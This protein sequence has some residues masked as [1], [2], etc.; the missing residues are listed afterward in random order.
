MKRGYGSDH[1]VCELQ[2][3]CDS[4]Q[5][6]IVTLD[7]NKRGI[8]EPNGEWLVKTWSVSSHNIVLT[9]N[10]ATPDRVQHDAA[11]RGVE[12]WLEHRQGSCRT[13]IQSWITPRLPDEFRGDDLDYAVGM[14][15]VRTPEVFLLEWE[16]VRRMKNFQTC[17][18]PINPLPIVNGPLR[19]PGAFST[20][21]EKSEVST[22]SNAEL[23]TDELALLRKD[24]WARNSRV[25]YRLP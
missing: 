10:S 20:R 25:R 17:S 23:T 8:V 1:P 19:V 14:F 9:G 18:L 4:H 22:K 3:G 16:S 15:L 11:T 2:G 5:E 6:P 21:L 7:G 24:L 12:S 13:N